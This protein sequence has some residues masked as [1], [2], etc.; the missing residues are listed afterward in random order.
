MSRQ[1]KLFLLVGLMVILSSLAVVQSMRVYHALHQVKF[2]VHRDRRPGD[3]VQKWT[4]VAEAAKSLNISKKEVFDALQIEPAT[5][6]E[7]LTFRALEKKYSKTPL[8]MQSNLRQLRER[9]GPSGKNH[10]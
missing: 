9:F 8:E 6:D 3:I 5:G 2:G 1:V 7:N 4:T 10:E